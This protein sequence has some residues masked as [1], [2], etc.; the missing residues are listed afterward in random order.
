MNLSKQLPAVNMEV[1][2]ACF[3]LSTLV[4]Y[5]VYLSFVQSGQWCDFKIKTY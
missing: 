1:N 5:V 2:N 4:M 3:L